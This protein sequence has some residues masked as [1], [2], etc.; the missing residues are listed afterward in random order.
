MRMRDHWRALGIDD[1]LA[2]ADQRIE[3][4]LGYSTK[5]RVRVELKS[6]L[7]GPLDLNGAQHVV[8]RNVTNPPI[9]H[10]VAQ[11]THPPEHPFAFRLLA[12][13]RTAL[14]AMRGHP[15]LTLSE[16]HCEGFIFALSSTGAVASV[17]SFEQGGIVTERPNRYS[18]DCMACGRYVEP[19]GGLLVEVGK[20]AGRHRIST[21]RPA[22]RVV[23]LGC[24]PTSA[25]GY[26]ID[27]LAEEL[28]SRFD[29][30]LPPEEVW[31]EVVLPR[32]YDIEPE[33]ASNVSGG[34]AFLRAH[35][36]LPAEPAPVLVRPCLVIAPTVE[37]AVEI[38]NRLERK[39]AQDALAA[40][41]QSEAWKTGEHRAEQA[42]ADAQLDLDPDRLDDGRDPW[43][44][45]GRP[46][47]D[48]YR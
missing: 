22:H 11:C 18:A 7:D 27:P 33:V 32:A 46:P 35:G 26:R 23:H 28:L 42:M 25:L 34:V 13:N 43:R 45:R 10:F 48:R 20:R 36:L 1:D 9:A 24:W 3:L 40:L 31:P 21:T 8:L 19:G 15:M 29:D 16:A 41:M 5:H 39:A 44:W 14:D 37:S 4:S 12:N 47:L 30:R 2:R 17:A 38:A 6:I